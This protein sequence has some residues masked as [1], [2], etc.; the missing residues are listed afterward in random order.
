MLRYAK[1]SGN[2]VM[3]V[4]LVSLGRTQHSLGPLYY[5][6]AL[7]TAGMTLTHLFVCTIAPTI[8]PL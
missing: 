2:A 1:D 5:F 3:V 8:A 6:A 4:R 7:H